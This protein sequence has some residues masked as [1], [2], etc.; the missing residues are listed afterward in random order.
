LDRSA[1]GGTHVRATGE[2]G[3]VLLRKLEKIRNTVRVEFLC[4][5]RAVGRARADYE[6]LNR[7]AQIFSSSLDDAP[8]VVAA[9]ME[10]ARAADKAR[11]K[12]E[13]DL[14]GYQG[15]ELYQA[16]APGTDGIRRA[17]RRAPSASLDDLRALAQSF[18][19]QPR[20]VFVATLANPPSVLMATSADAGVDAG[21]RLKAALAEAG[22]RGGGSP[23]MAQG[24]VPDGAQLDKVVEKLGCHEASC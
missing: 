4:G 11:R 13:L 19:A 9:Q 18:T 8:G 5:G 24:S 10:T 21:Q 15:R 6:A 14:A 7:V 2:I 16:T 20:A 22:G 23:R 12:L 17:V 1:C 3:A